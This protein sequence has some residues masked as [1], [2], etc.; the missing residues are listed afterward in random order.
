MANKTISM[1]KVRQIIKLYSQGI[2]KKRIAIRLAVS[3]NTVKEYIVSFIKLR[4]HWDELSKLT[5]FELNKL[6]HPSTETLLNQRVQQLYDFFPVMERNMRR[7][8]MTVAIQYRE[9][10]AN[11]PESYAETSF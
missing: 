10:K 2:G 7:R 11:H 4:I 6:F 5:D 1:S 9:F 8:G 3:K